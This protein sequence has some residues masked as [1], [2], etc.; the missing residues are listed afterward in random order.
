MAPSSVLGMPASAASC[1]SSQGVL[2]AH[3]TNFQ[4]VKSKAAPYGCEG[5]KPVAKK[6]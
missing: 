5:M 6:R 3:S 1:T 2:Q 4:P